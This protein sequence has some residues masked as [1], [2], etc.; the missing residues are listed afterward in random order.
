[1]YAEIADLHVVGKESPPTSENGRDLDSDEVEIWEGHGKRTPE[2]K[3]HGKNCN[4]IEQ[5]LPPHLLPLPPKAKEKKKSK[6]LST[7]KPETALLSM[8]AA[9]TAT[10]ISSNNS[11]GRISGSDDPARAEIKGN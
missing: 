6:V 3:K 2:P 8:K 11:V 9:T 10:T 1:M 5:N 4:T 7:T